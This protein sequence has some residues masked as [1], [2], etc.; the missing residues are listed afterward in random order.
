MALSTVKFAGIDSDIFTSG[1]ADSAQVQSQFDSA[2][3]AGTIGIGTSNPGQ[4]LDIGDHS[5]VGSRS[6]R[7][8]QRTGTGEVTY[9]GIEFYYNNTAGTEGVNAAI[10]YA[11]GPL[12]NDGEITFHTGSSASISE[13]MRID[14]N[15]NVGIGI[16]TP[17]DEL[18]VNSTGANVNLRLTRDS[19]TGAS[20]T[21][22]DGANTPAIRFD[23]IASGVGTERMRIDQNGNVGI[24]TTNPIGVFADKVVRISGDSGAEIILRRNDAGV[25]GGE[26]IGG[27]LFNNGDTSGEDPHYAGM[28]GRAHTIYGPT[29]L[30]FYSGRGSV[31]DSSAVPHMLIKAGT[32]EN[33]EVGI[34]ID[35]PQAT[36]HVKSSDANTKIGVWNSGTAA[37]SRYAQILLTQGSTFFGASDKSWQLVSTGQS[38]GTTQFQI[39]NWN[40]SAYNTNAT[41]YEDGNVNMHNGVRFGS[42]T[43]AAN[44]LDD[45]E[46]GT[47]TPTLGT[48]TITSYEANYTKIG[49]IVQMQIYIN[50]VSDITTAANFAL[51]LPFTSKSNARSAGSIMFR[52]INS[53][54]AVTSGTDS[55][56]TPYVSSNSSTLYLYLSRNQGGNYVSI[57]H[58]DFTNTGLDM[59][60]TLTYIAA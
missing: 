38:D 16:A 12:R 45:Y 48:G 47:W 27:F 24:G 36:L 40:G 46:E 19:S 7:I 34:G 44:T 54:G 51:S 8:S 53:G 23:T 37:A 58:N 39:Q 43:A 18:H 60:I 29:Q 25:L 33:P 2:L 32:D 56:V 52:Y 30:E 3:A 5:T 11:A 59:F 17:A 21:A 14:H 31:E 13:A 49:N 41:F 15:G 35:D 57:Q 4:L 55:Q 9:G 10:K 6:L 20:I 1:V 50:G 42:D 26:Y 22:S 28:V